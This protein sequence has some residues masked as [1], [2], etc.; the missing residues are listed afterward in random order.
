MHVDWI[1]SSSKNVKLAY[2]RAESG[3][4]FSSDHFPVLAV[5]ADE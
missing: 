5:L 2:V 1:L 4:D 3:P